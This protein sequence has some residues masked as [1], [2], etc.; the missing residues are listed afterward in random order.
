MYIYIFTRRVFSVRKYTHTSLIYIYCAREIY[1]DRHHIYIYNACVCVR[2]IRT[3]VRSFRPPLPD[4]PPAGRRRRRRR[5]V[6]AASA[7]GGSKLQS[8]LV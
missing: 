6:A 8:A 4:K 2:R 1:T 3:F 5:L 7:S